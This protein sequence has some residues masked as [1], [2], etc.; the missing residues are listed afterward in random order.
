[1]LASKEYAIEVRAVYRAPI[2][3]R[4]M[5]GV[6]HGSACLETGNAGIVHQHIELAMLRYHRVDHMLPLSLV[7]H[8]E[9]RHC[10]AWAEP[11]GQAGGSGG[12][13]V[14]NPNLRAFNNEGFGNGS[15]NASR[16]TCYQGD[17]TVKTC[18]AI[19][20]LLAKLSL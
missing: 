18:H 16:R 1:M 10:R 20:L 3:Q 8:I 11:R 14:G 5:F 6:V 17:L 9:A 13:D 19:P 12:I 4:C 2:L 7:A 15:T